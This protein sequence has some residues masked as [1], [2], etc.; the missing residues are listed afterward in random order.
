MRIVVL[1][2]ALLVASCG[3]TRQQELQQTFDTWIGHPV[4]D[5][6]LRF[7]PPNS[8]FDLGP[9]QR[10]FQWQLTGQ[11]PGIAAPIGGMMVYRPPQQTVCMVSFSASADKSAPTLADWVIYSWQ[12]QGVC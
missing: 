10:A 8:S 4:S 9:K 12:Y 1:M 7:G 5:Y 11:T 3:P 2:L 6:A